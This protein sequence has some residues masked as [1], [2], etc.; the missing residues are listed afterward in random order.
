MSNVL[1]ELLQI[2]QG[3]EE[4]GDAIPVLGDDD[5]MS[6][7]AAW[8]RADQVWS[9]P[10]AKQPPYTAKTSEAVWRWIC[11][12]WSLD[13]VVEAIERGT[14]LSPFV[15]RNKLAMLIAA[16]LIYPDG[17]MSKAAKTALQ[18]HV[19]KKLGIKPKRRKDPAGDPD[20]GGKAIN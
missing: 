9:Q 14:G 1:A 18:L 17:N 5:A 11:A 3:T 20:G 8:R 4:D 13:H 2:F 15:V 12:G 7:L 16:R 19:A 10:N 6:V